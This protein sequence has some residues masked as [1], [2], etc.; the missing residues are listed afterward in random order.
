MKA[1]RELMH[2]RS[3]RRDVPMKPQVVAHELNK[4]LTD[5][6]IVAADSGTITS[7]AARHID[8]RGKMKFSVSGTLA[9]M[10][11][12]VPKGRLHQYRPEPYP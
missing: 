3:T 5:D 10:A 2:E 11:C 6:A 12:G 1:W 4:L 9:S 7:W 8:V